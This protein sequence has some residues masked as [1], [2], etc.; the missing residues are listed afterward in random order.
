MITFQDIESYCK[1]RKIELSQ[2]ELDLINK[3]SRWA[4]EEIGKLRKEE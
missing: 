1:M 3:M 4:G 2:Y